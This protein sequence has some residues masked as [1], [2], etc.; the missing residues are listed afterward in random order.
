MKACTGVAS[1]GQARLGTIINLVPMSEGPTWEAA[2]MVA[3]RRA[4]KREREVSVQSAVV[5][6]DEVVRDDDAGDEVV[7]H[8]D[9]EGKKLGVTRRDHAGCLDCHGGSRRDLRRSKVTMQVTY[10]SAA[11]VLE[12]GEEET[13]SVVKTMHEGLATHAERGGALVAWNVGVWG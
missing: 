12:V 8:E 1:T 6:V 4:A 5:G 7:V 10:G 13:V 2:V 3:V 11:V 9:V